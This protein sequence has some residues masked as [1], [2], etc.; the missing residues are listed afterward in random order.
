MLFP[1][2]SIIPYLGIVLSSGMLERH[3]EN[4]MRRDTNGVSYLEARAG[5]Q[6]GNDLS[7]QAGG[8]KGKTQLLRNA[9]ELQLHLRADFLSQKHKG[10]KKKQTQKINEQ[11]MPCLHCAS[12]VAGL[13]HSSHAKIFT[14]F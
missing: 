11:W 9:L 1:V 4:G 13:E 5:F 8:I 14:R 12:V 10:K 3:N 2:L 6:T 7:I